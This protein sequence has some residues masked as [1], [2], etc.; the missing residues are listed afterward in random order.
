MEQVAMV[1]VKLPVRHAKTYPVLPMDNN[2]GT[3]KYGIADGF[4]LLKPS[5]PLVLNAVCMCL[6]ILAKLARLHPFSCERGQVV[7]D[8][9]ERLAALVERKGDRKVKHVKDFCT[10]LHSQTQE[11]AETRKGTQELQR[12]QNMIGPAQ[13]LAAYYALPSYIGC[14]TNDAFVMI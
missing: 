13:V 12:L 9:V 4:V 2:K 6:K 5:I 11:T 8:L 1:F 7:L 10:F 14:W 3:N